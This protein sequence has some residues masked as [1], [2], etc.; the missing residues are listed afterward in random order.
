[1]PQQQMA[2][3]ETGKGHTAESYVTMQV[4]HLHGPWYIHAWAEV[5]SMAGSTRLNG[6][7]DYGNCQL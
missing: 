7:A 6:A 5:A 3:R 1:M 2:R 4:F